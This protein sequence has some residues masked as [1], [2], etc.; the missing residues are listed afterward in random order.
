MRVETLEN[1]QRREDVGPRSGQLEREWE[2]LQARAQRCNVTQRVVTWIESHIDSTSALQK[3][4]DRR[5]PAQ[6]RGIKTLVEVGNDERSQD[7]ALFPAQVQG[8][9]TGDQDLHLGTAFQEVTDDESG[10]PDV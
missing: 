5:I 6:F 2:T 3:Q 7:E 1:C 9:P 4:G 8:L 10:T